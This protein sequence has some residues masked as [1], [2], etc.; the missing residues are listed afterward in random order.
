[1]GRK[2]RRRKIASILRKAK[3]RRKL[4][5]DTL[6]DPQTVTGQSLCST[7]E[8]DRQVERLVVAKGMRAEEVIVYSEEEKSSGESSDEASEATPESSSWLSALLSYFW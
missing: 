7:K 5:A 4:E 8:F 3:Q 1:M 2:N 6:A